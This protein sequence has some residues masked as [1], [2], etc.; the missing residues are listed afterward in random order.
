[1]GEA[2]SRH[3]GEEK[4]LQ[5]WCKI[6]LCF[7]LMGGLQTKSMTS[8][9]NRAAHNM[10]DMRYYGNVMTTTRWRLYVTR[11]TLWQQQD[12][13]DVFYIFNSTVVDCTVCLFFLVGKPGKKSEC[14]EE[15]ME[16][17]VW[18]GLI[19]HGKRIRDGS[20]WKIFWNFGLKN[21]RSFLSSWETLLLAVRWSGDNIVVG[22]LEILVNWN[23]FPQTVLATFPAP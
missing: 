7:R 22:M 17:K 15:K 5:Y 9:R 11:E 20:L 6:H 4:Y 2:C 21:A 16:P 18:S 19:W 10:A 14:L 8:Q 23:A 3:G 12:V 13:I 1:M